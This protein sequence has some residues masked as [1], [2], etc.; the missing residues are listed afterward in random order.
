MIKRNTF[1][2]R[3]NPNDPFIIFIQCTGAIFAEASAVI[4]ISQNVLYAKI[5]F[6]QQINPP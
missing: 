3:A 2:E 1:F 6:I 4:A 5:F